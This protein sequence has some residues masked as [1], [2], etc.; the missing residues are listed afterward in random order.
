MI[1]QN[2]TKWQFTLKYIQTQMFSNKTL[3]VSK[4]LSFS[5]KHVHANAKLFQFY[6]LQLDLSLPAVSTGSNNSLSMDQQQANRNQLE[7]NGPPAA[8]EFNQ[9]MYGISVV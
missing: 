6:I 3:L 9:G 5:R 7:R 2:S 8:V 4:Y 1:L